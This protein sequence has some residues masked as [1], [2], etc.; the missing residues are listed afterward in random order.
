MPESKEFIVDING[1][2]I[3]SLKE[4]SGGKIAN[5][6]KIVQ[7]VAGK[8]NMFDVP[9]ADEQRIKVAPPFR[10]EKGKRLILAVGYKN[11]DE[12]DGRIHIYPVWVGLID[13]N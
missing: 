11:V 6:E 8:D 10:L 3:K 1:Y 12:A 5:G 9:L 2:K 7:L 4:L 13:V